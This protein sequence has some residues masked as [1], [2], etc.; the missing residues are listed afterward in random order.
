METIGSRIRLLRTS[1]RLTQIQLADLLDIKQNTLSELE[2]GKSVVM[3][4][5]T[6]EAICRVLVTTP[7]FVLYG[8]RNGDSVE[9]AMMEAELTAIFRELPEKAQEALL[10]DA[11]L[12]R[13]AVPINT[14]V[15][16]LVK[17]RKHPR[18][19]GPHESSR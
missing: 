15:Q 7:S 18:V 3:S 8:V 17:D 4:A 2:T 9:T 12:V 19:K 1:Q 6:L 13:S 16:P 10:K 14:P 5:T 11:R